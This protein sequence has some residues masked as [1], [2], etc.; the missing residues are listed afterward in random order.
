VANESTD[1]RLMRVR[2]VVSVL[3]FGANDV[4]IGEDLNFKTWQKGGGFDSYGEWSVILFS[5]IVKFWIWPHPDE[6]P[7]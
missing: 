4:G 2:P 7:L 1:L 3:A 5:S 6:N